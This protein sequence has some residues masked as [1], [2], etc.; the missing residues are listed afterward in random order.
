[1]SLQLQTWPLVAQSPAGS[2]DVTVL[3][4]AR[5]AQGNQLA[6]EVRA[7]EPLTRVHPSERRAQCAL[8]E[9]NCQE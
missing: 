4:G 9:Q 3:A 1:M 6:S 8:K 7:P 5:L 2:G